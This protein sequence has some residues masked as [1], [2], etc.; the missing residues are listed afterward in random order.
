MPY[1]KKT[2]APA[3]EAEAPAKE[4]QEPQPTHCV[5]YTKVDPKHIF[6]QVV[7]LGPSVCPVC[8]YDPVIVNKEK[9]LVE[10]YDELDDEGK[11]IARNVL[12]K[13]RERH[14]AE[15]IA[16]AKIRNLEVSEKVK[17]KSQK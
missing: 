10:S 4:V 7:P 9:F 15:E 6:S 13:H 17:P 5:R 14:S 3:V 8:G 16:A 1:R 12:A 2:V 11:L